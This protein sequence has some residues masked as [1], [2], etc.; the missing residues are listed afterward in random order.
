M[1]S[2]ETNKKE[3]VSYGT[4][5]PITIEKNDFYKDGKPFLRPN[6][7]EKYS[8]LS[9][10]MKKIYEAISKMA[11]D[12]L[13]NQKFIN[14]YNNGKDDFS[15]AWFQLVTDGYKK[16]VALD[17]GTVKDIGFLFTI[18]YERKEII[19]NKEVISYVGKAFPAISAEERLIRLKG[20]PT[21]NL[22]RYLMFLSFL[23][24]YQTQSLNI[25]NK[26]GK[27]LSPLD[28]DKLHTNKNDIETA[29][30]YFEKHKTDLPSMTIEVYA[31]NPITYSD[32]CKFGFDYNIS[33][34]EN[35][36]IKKEF[37][38]ISKNWDPGEL[39]RQS[40]IKSLGPGPDYL[41]HN[42]PF[43]VNLTPQEWRKLF[44]HVSMIDKDVRYYLWQNFN[45]PNSAFK[46]IIPVNEY[47]V[48]QVIKN[49]PEIKEELKNQITSRFENKKQKNQK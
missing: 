16:N 35:E 34:R 3:K 14:F 32:L 13:T 31:E 10:N 41:E 42:I 24:F 38:Y 44:T 27:N 30:A 9:E 15:G 33:K 23:P 28:I 40:Y 36:A 19:N 45:F 11:V 20:G 43:T 37:E 5:K 2:K 17:D 46:V 22:E 1:S 6:E 12:R 47:N 39:M 4:R 18:F 48:G 26:K 8:E 25:L 7:K 49:H 21:R 29:L